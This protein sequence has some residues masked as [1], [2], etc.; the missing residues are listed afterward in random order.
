M[1]SAVAKREPRSVRTWDPFQAIREEVES[2]WPSLARDRDSA[3]LATL[4]V[5]PID[6]SET[7]D[8]IQ[9]T[10]DLPGIKP[11]EIDIQLN[12][13]VLTISGQRRQEKEE[14]DKTFHRI[15]RRSGSFSRSIT[16]PTSVDEDKVDA[17]CKDGILRISMPKTEA[18]KSHRIK[19]KS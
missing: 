9:I 19:V 16:L 11:D 8:A 10:M 3:W 18:A 14:K 6:L 15:E 5:P 12:N 7:A 2:L 4:A 13:H 17:Q 1:T